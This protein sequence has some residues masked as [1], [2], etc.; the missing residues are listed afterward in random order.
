MSIVKF[1]KAALLAA[2][3]VV[4]FNATATGLVSK[5]QSATATEISGL[6]AA[7]SKFVI[8]AP[9]SGKAT[10]DKL[11]VSTVGAQGK[12]VVV[13]RSAYCSDGC[14]SGCSSGCS[15][16]CSGGCSV[17]CSIGCR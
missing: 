14:S 17:G 5:A 3:C 4:S 16:G 10:L 6:G 13:E 11:A 1:V 9:V 15:V 12:G 2:V 7:D 8:A